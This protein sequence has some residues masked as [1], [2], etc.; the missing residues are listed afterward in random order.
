M[1]ASLSTPLSQASTAPDLSQLRTWS[2]GSSDFDQDKDAVQDHFGHVL[3]PNELPCLLLSRDPVA[4]SYFID[5]KEE[6]VKPRLCPDSFLGD[7]KGNMGVFELTSETPNED[8]MTRFSSA[9][10]KPIHIFSSSR[11]EWA[12]KG[13][14]SLLE[15][16]EL[17]LWLL[18]GSPA[19]V[20]TSST[21]MMSL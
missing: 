3:A 8:T 21:Y 9:A 16:D 17:A 1:S 19:A 7:E 10:A 6:F 11:A 4:E 15:G 5:A 13:E 2:L 20:L 14:V 18:S 12:C